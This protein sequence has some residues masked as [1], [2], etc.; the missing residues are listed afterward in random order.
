[1]RHITMLLMSGVLATSLVAGCSDNDDTPT[2]PTAPTA[3]QPAAAAGAGRSPWRH[4]RRSSRRRRLRR[5]FGEDRRSLEH[6]PAGP[7]RPG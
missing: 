3:V 1:M 6:P 2:A 5:A 4:G 7:V